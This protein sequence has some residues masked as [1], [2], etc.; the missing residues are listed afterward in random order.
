MSWLKGREERIPNSREG[1]TGNSARYRRRG[2]QKEQRGQE[3]FPGAPRER[4]GGGVKNPFEAIHLTPKFQK[5]KMHA[6]IGMEEAIA[7]GK[8]P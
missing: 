1:P 6:V 7:L 3:R 8:R 4:R 5:K 2:Q